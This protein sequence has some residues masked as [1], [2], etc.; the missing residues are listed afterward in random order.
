M[1]YMFVL[2]ECWSCGAHFCFSAE[3]V[4]SIPIKGVRQPICRNC[5]DLANQKRAVNGLDPI[6]VLPGA[7]EPDEA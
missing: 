2:G 7:Y 5:I 1:G 3:R 4:P 6:P